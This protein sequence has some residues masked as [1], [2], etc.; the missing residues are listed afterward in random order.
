MCKEI[1]CLCSCDLVRVHPPADGGTFL[2]VM[3]GPVGAFCYGWV[4][5]GAVRYQE[6]RMRMPCIG[7]EYHGIPIYRKG[8]PKPAPPYKRAFWEWDGNEDQ[9]TLTPSISTK[10]A[11]RD[12]VKR[13]AGEL[14]E[15][16][17]GHVTAG[18]L[19]S[20]P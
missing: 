18:R 6:L 2:A 20:C 8:E 19:V 3:S 7:W 12:P 1:R 9:P 4:T 13:R 11:H 16:W 15:V 17:H 5:D 10:M 14:E